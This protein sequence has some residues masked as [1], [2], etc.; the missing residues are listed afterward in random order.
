MSCPR[1]R[2]SRL[3]RIGALGENGYHTPRFQLEGFDLELA[4]RE[5]F[6]EVGAVDALEGTD[7]LRVGVVVG[8]IIVKAAALCGCC[9]GVVGY[10]CEEE[11]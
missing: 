6:V 5:R 2:R 10:R 4:E 9:D 1:K 8:K 7:G 11:M 3:T